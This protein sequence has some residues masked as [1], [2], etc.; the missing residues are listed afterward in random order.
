MM[1]KNTFALAASIMYAV[2]LLVPLSPAHAVTSVAFG[3]DCL[4]RCANV[5]LNTGDPWSGSI[6]LLDAVAVP[7]GSFTESDVLGFQFSIGIVF[8]NDASA[9]PGSRLSGTFDSLGTS[10]DRFFIGLSETLQPVES[11]TIVLALNSNLFQA[12]TLG[13]CAEVTCSTITLFEPAV[14]SIAQAATT[15][16]EPGSLGLFVLGL[17][18]LCSIKRRLKRG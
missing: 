6:D 11:D 2:V 4:S 9:L 15:V 1:F 7:D 18:G 5:G 16:P 12:T 14:L 13:S 10:L 8:I 17:V 3:G